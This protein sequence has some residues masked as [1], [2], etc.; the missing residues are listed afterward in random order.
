MEEIIK[1]H[2]FEDA[3]QHIQTFSN[4]TSNNLGLDKVETNGGLFGWFD[5]NVTGD[6]LNRVTGQVQDYLIK[7][8]GLHSDFIKEFGQVYKA[9][10]SLD[11]EYIP[12][13]LC[14]VKGAEEA[15]NQAK[16][17]QQDINET[18]E[19][20]KK[21]IKV[22]SDHKQKL[23]KLAH[24]ENVDEI[25]NDIVKFDKEVNRFNKEIKDINNKLNVE[26]TSIS[27]LKKYKESLSKKKHIED[28]DTMWKNVESHGSSIKTL[29]IKEDKV[30]SHIKSIVEEVSGNKEKVTLA[31]FAIE[32]IQNEIMNINQAYMSLKK[33]VEDINSYEHLKDIDILWSD[34][35]KYKL[36]F[37]VI[38]N[39]VGENTTRIEVVENQVSTFEN[40]KEGVTKQEHYL[41]I[42]IMFD[43][44]ENNG[45]EIT[46]IK[47][48]IQTT[49]KEVETIKEQT[50]ELEK[51]KEEV[52]KQE[53][54]L[55]ID[56]IFENTGSEIA[57]INNTLQINKKEAEDIKDRTD[58][59]EK[60]K[61]NITKQEHYLEVDVMSDNIERNSSEIDVINN[62]ILAN[63]KEVDEIKEQLLQA[64]EETKNVRE[65]YSKRVIMAY[66]IAGSAIGI[67]ILELLL[68]MLGI[69]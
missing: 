12:A 25:W 32:N 53:H 48:T 18:I 17:A 24:L 59:L 38:S 44:I 30:E 60:F 57:L 11:K 43:D 14:S 27:A 36:S 50:C 47:N 8:N 23:D 46:S 33:I 52:T 37:E 69:M 51:F 26:N 67:S 29:E 65:K 54:Y 19:T 66:A 28:I 6:E 16:S 41:D 20:Q 56:S 1:P 21:V 64:A 68:S 34:F 49:K 62:A 39:K 31:Q 3:K 22:L 35:E 63:K 58:E 55:D 4:R 40:F 2:S 45:S 9:L 42:D 13:I 15:S 61:E 5:H 10:E 7:F